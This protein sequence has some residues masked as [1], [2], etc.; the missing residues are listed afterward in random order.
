MTN[1]IQQL[2]QLGQSIW[3]DNIQR[4]MITSG[5]LKAMTD[6]GLLGMTSNPTIFEKAIGGSSDY[7]ESLR[8]LIGDG[9]GALE[10]YD[11]LTIEDV[12]LAADVFRSVFDRTKG[13]D[14][15]VSIE[16]S[17]KLAHDTAGTLADARRLWKTLARPNVMI[18]IP[19][20]KAGLPAIEQA[21]AEGINVNITLMFSMEHYEA[22]A[23]AYLSGL[24]RRVKAGKP[25][26][27][28]ASVASFFVSRVDTL[29]D[30]KL[31]E[32]IRQEGSN[33]ALAASLQGKAA[34]ANSQLVYERF[35]QIF[36]SDRFKKLQAKGAMAQRVLWA[37]T[38]TKNPKYP[39][40]IYV[41]TLIGP[42]T[43]NTVPPE[44]YEAIKDHATAK[45]TVDA[46]FDSARKVVNELES[47]GL[48][49]H[50]IGEQ[51]SIE[52][53]EKFS[54][55][56]DQL[57]KVIDE[58]RVRLMAENVKFGTAAL[59]SY[60]AQVDERLAAFEHAGVIRRVWAKDAL[61]W[62][63]ALEHIAEI[64]NRL[65]WL[66]VIDAMKDKVADLRS[67]AD[68]VRSAGYTD[69]VVLGMG[70]SSMAP[71]LARLAFGNAKGFL[72]LHVL[73][74]TN[75]DAI[76]ALEKKIDPFKT[77]FIA[78]SKSGTTIE[79]ESLHRYFR[80]KLRPRLGDAYGQNFIAITD[81]ASPL[82]DMARDE[83]FRHVFINQADIGGRY[84]VLSYFGLV[85]M[86]LSGL[87]VE[88]LI[89]RARAMAQVCGPTVLA[90]ANPGVWLGAI[91]GELAQSGRDKITFI[92]SKQITSFGYWVE[93]LIAESTGKLGKG[94]VPIEGEEVGTPKVY[95]NDRLFV[96]MKLKG[97]RS[98]DAKVKA[99]AKAGQPIVTL[100]LDDLYDLGAEFFRW[101]MATVIASAVLQ[102]DPLDQPNVT[103]SKNNT[104][105]ILKEYVL[106]GVLSD[107]DRVNAQQTESVRSALAALFKQVQPGDYVA[108]MAYLP[109]TPAI[110]R[111]LQTLR[112]TLRDRLKVATTIGYGPRFLHSTGQL[113][114]GGANK[115]V[116][117]QFTADAVHDLKIEGK[118]FSFGTLIRAQAL[119]DLQALRQR[120]YR[121]IRIHLGTDVIGG[122]R[123]TQRA[124]DQALGA[125]KS[126]KKQSATRTAAKKPI[127]RSTAK[128]IKSKQA[129]KKAKK[130]KRKYSFASEVEA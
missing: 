120:N 84:S 4:K 8:Q 41:N 129:K 7:D 97:D 127:K 104:G 30:A 101:E 28:I 36:G 42:D 13:A 124:I 55:S 27:R 62:S 57:L 93:Q 113:H 91:M 68:E 95:G 33:A 74:T 111:A 6:E 29:I 3:Y 61:V 121:V 128:K 35:Q 81:P 10:V 115:G 114:K 92:L 47:L 54:K 40:T 31:A 130:S 118:E 96:V 103:E 125:K 69:A 110:D 77:L 89:D 50:D 18:K 119:G 105:A 78:A 87:D 112:V 72:K 102:L 80:S 58:K 38:S 53:V 64:T 48:Q 94:I 46:D 116:F 24:E 123:S 44:T 15:Y 60:Q 65:G 83:K 82:A 73:D 52:G 109:T 56:F 106:T 19:A 16:V 9:K 86:A 63:S 26:D 88:R 90:V 25:I 12:G 34:V 122:L 20:T 85:P 32:I 76:A 108:T 126:A 37:S 117:I 98:L 49:L 43:V 23:E 66:T 21:L 100:T 67:F 17:P 107:D 59:G 70:G 22:V 99:L 11:A 2:S 71:D 1:R 5:K 51:L 14:G 79:I 75:P 39:D 45:R